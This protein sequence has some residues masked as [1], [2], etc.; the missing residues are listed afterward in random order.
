MSPPRP[1]SFEEEGSDASASSEGKGPAT[2]SADGEGSVAAAASAAFEVGGRSRGQRRVTFHPGDG[3][4]RRGCGSLSSCGGPTT[5]RDSK[6]NKSGRG[7]IN[8][9]SRGE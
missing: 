7:G 8:S 9:N 3:G 5:P 2:V 6:N 4:G 1:T